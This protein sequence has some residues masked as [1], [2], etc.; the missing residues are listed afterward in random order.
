M[1]TAATIAG[2]A[3]ELTDIELRNDP[4]WATFIGIGGYDDAVPDLSPT[5]QQEWRDRLIDI[6]V[7]CG[8][9]P[10]DGDAE[11][12][13]LLA[14]VRDK[15]TRAL[16]IADSR[17]DE[18]SVTT[19]PLTGPSLMLLVAARTQVND[20][21]AAT[22]YLARCRRLSTY[23][24]QCATVLQT[25]AQAGLLPVAPLVSDAIRQLHDYLSHPERDPLLSRQPPEGWA[26]AAAW[27]E[28][29][30]QIVQAEVRPAV[31]RYADLLAE[32][33]PKSRPPERAGLIHVPGGVAAYACS[34]RMGTTMPYDPD[35]LHRIGLSD[36][37]E[38]E[39]R[40]AEL[41]SR[42]IGTRDA[43]D[44]MTRLRDDV[45]LAPSD[46][47]A[48]MARSAEVIA[49]AHQCLPD[50]FRPPF[51][52][53]C[54]VEPMPRHMAQFGGPPYYSPPA[55]DGSKRGAYLFNT[56]QPGA[57]GSWALETITFHET[58]PGHHVQFAR[59][60]LVQ[61]LPR[62][63][64]LFYVIPHGEGWGLYA[65]RLADEFGLYSDDLQRL[66]MLGSAAWRAVRLVVDTGLHARGWSRNRARK[67]A[68]DHSPMPEDFVDAEIDRYIAV[69][70]QAL[71]YHIGQREIL[72]LRDNAKAKLRS[73]FDIRDFHSAILDHGLLPLP[74]L[75]QVVEAWAAAPRPGSPQVI[76][77]GSRQQAPEPTVR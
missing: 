5:A 9:C 47:T 76:K 18:F 54:A 75:R 46:G 57:A 50:M 3:D 35:E 58:I 7:R 67:F 12:N 8:Q 69:P 66:G 49:R 77:T 41:G 24:D 44:V 63:L 30:S 19:M 73:D 65:E 36:L 32:L 70:G 51:P 6:I 38:I 72:R 4:F 39:E 31:G 25:A 1:T 64:A 48:A 37:S 20:S 45:T 52:P 42:A 56:A 55:R 17:I 15:A 13:V 53:P 10:A 61:H 11:S 16:A 2:L 26:G 29:V 60:Q 27:Q 34:V 28:E 74:V 40:I 59:L 62:L 68:V 23:L 22:A 71:G 21:A 33:L 43:G 14:A